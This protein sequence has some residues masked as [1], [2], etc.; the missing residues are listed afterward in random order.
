LSNDDGGPAAGVTQRRF[1]AGPED[2]IILPLVL[3]ALAARKLLQAAL[4]V[5]VRILDY[6][7]PIF[8][9]LMRFPLFTARIIGDGIAALLGGLVGYLP[10][11][12]SKREAWRQL[13]SRHWSW[14]RRKIS[15]KAFEEAV[16]HAFESG[17][18]WVFRR[19]RD[20]TPTVALLVIA[21]AVLWLPVS[22][23]V[24]TAMHA[25]LIAQ[26]ASLPAWMQLLHPVA[27]VIAKTK[28]LVLPVYPAA[29]PQAKRHPSV[30]AVSRFYRWFKSLYVIQKT[31]YRYWEAESAL[32]EASDA[33]RRAAC[34]VGLCTLSKTLSGY[35]S[36]AAGTIGEW[37]RVATVRAVEGLSTV[38][39]VGAIVQ[40]YAEHYEAKNR[41]RGERFSEKARGVFARWSIKFSAEYYEAKEKGEATKRQGLT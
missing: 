2:V 38:P 39:L 36:R 23:G 40:R 20:L 4:S 29:W 11:S 41:Q 34:H 13:V 37:V 28:L 35:I 6:A 33:L 21:G 12:A 10:V 14:L 17:M 32:A 30:Q 27:T 26:A 9:Q 16:H 3:L 24:A 31:G 5:L 15:Y 25:V 1:T 8:L 19:C 22:F 18:A 7:F